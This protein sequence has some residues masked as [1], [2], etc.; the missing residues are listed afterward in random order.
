MTSTISFPAAICSIVS[1][2]IATGKLA[3][4]STPDQLER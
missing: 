3:S 2:G 4:L 1:D